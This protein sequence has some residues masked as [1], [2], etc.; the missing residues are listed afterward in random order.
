MK[1]ISAI[2]CRLYQAGMRF[3]C[4]LIKWPKPR[5]IKGDDALNKMVEDFNK[6]EIKKPM[7]IMPSFLYKNPL[8][9]NVLKTFEHH[10]EIRDLINPTVAAVEEIV[11][12]Y[13]KENCDAM[14]VIGGGSVIDLGKGAA[15]RIAHPRKT[16]NKMKGVLKLNHK[17]IP[18]Y[19]VPT[20]A[21]SG[22][23]AT[24]CAVITDEATHE[25]SS[26]ND[27]HLVPQVAVLDPRLTV[28]L[29]PYL[30]ATTGMDALTHAIESYIGNSNTRKTKKD[31][32]QAT[33]LILDNI[34]EA[35]LNGQ[36]L[37]ARQAMQE[38]ALLAGQ[39]FTRAYVGYVHAR[40]N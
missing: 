31:A 38:A 21:G 26:I 5:V 8:I 12:I 4:N 19:A 16:I 40:E 2:K 23:E 10:L 22:S 33:K 13:K 29:P 24:V 27:P 18:L 15:V 11:E 32:I 30:T 17:L 25:K 28:S 3:A 36:N 7:V 34:E 9:K 20:T 1:T 6:R 14:V 35:T 37:Q 39:A